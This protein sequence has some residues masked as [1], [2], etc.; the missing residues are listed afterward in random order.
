MDFLDRLDD[1]YK[2]T[3]DYGQD[4]TSFLD[5]I[6]SIKMI[7]IPK[8]F[9]V[10]EVNDNKSSGIIL[11]YDAV[12]SRLGEEHPDWELHYLDENSGL[13]ILRDYFPSLAVYWDKVPTRKCK[14]NIIRYAWLSINGGVSIETSISLNKSIDSLFY[15]DSEI[16]LLKD[17]SLKNA[18][19]TEIIASKRKSRFWLEVLKEIEMRLNN[20]PWWLKGE[21]FID[22]YLTGE[23]LLIDVAERT[24]T[25]Y[26]IIPS[27]VVTTQNITALNTNK[28]YVNSA[29]SCYVSYKDT[30]L[31]IMTIII[32]ILL[33]VILVLVFYKNK[34]SKEKDESF[35]YHHEYESPYLRSAR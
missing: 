35:N 10:V 14:E 8:K 27:P 24:S 17:S 13:N 21:Y 26:S 15:N 3:S 1:I 32:F 22:R 29:Y 6:G 11:G 28:G 5:S 23:D 4:D 7:T 12:K 31:I 33:I 34:P 2:R 16:Y 18:I 30:L 25:I 20:Q 9:C 19:S